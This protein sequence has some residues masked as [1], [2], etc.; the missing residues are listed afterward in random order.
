MRLIFSHK[1]SIVY[2]N[3]FLYYLY[4]KYTYVPNTFPNSYFLKNCNELLLL[5]F[6]LKKLLLLLKK[7][8]II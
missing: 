2:Y 8:V 1:I 7:E 4:N 6:F 5:I 3:L